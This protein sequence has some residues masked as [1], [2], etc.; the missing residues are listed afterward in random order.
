LH[1]RGRSVDTS[2]VYPQFKLT[3]ADSVRNVVLWADPRA[4]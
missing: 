2:I 4:M 3:H 1:G